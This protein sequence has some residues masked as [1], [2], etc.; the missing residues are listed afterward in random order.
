ML[1]IVIYFWDS[2][3]PLIREY[4]I[5][6]FIFILG[7]EQVPVTEKYYYFYAIASSPYPQFAGAV[8]SCYN[9]LVH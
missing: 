4:G 9:T 3:R 2:I 7:Q 6:D 1:E 5:H 8:L